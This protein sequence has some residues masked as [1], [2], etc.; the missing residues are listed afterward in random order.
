M[1]HPAVYNTTMCDTLC[2]NCGDATKT[3]VDNKIL[4]EMISNKQEIEMR[5]GCSICRN[6]RFLLIVTNQDENIIDGMF[7]GEEL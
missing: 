2:M 6:T 7:Q 5:V 1:T 3:H 4:A